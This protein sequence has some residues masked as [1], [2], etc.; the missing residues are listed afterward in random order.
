MRFRPARDRIA[1]VLLG[2]L[3]AGCAPLTEPRA[4]GVVSYSYELPET[5][6]PHQVIHA[7]E[8]A[9]ARTLEIPLKTIEGSVQS[10]LPIAPSDFKVETRRVRLDQL[11]VVFIPHI[12]CPGNMAMISS[13]TANPSAR[14]GLQAYAGCM[15]QYAGGYHVRIVAMETGSD[16]TV[17]LIPQGIASNTLTEHISLVAKKFVELVP[18]ARLVRASTLPPSGV[19]VQHPDGGPAT[20]H[21][22]TSEESLRHSQ[23]V[24]ADAKQESPRQPS[25]TEEQESPAPFPLLC[26]G[27]AGESLA[28][29][30]QPEG[31]TVLKV[32]GSGSLLTIEEP[33]DS[34]YF[35]V[36][37]EGGQTGWIRRSDVRRL[38]CPIG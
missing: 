29:Q 10:P 4:T 7:V 5:L 17:E 13:Y 25:H 35:R 24:E 9:L 3:V 32:L 20:K 23:S 1:L 28:V 6:E 34:A 11:G 16:D 36:R 12:E 33:V 37:V 38:L 22:T 30:S 14:L 21:V 19:T 27:P 18:S 26:V 2:L 15:Y 31:G 8:V